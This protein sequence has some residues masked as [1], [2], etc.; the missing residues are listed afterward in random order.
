MKCTLCNGAT[1]PFCNTNNKHYFKCLVCDAVLLDSQ[2]FITAEAE[3]KRYQLH[4]NNIED[5][6]YQ[7][8]VKPITDAVL[9]TFNNTQSGLDFG[10]GTGPVITKILRKKTFEMTTYDPFF[11]NNLNALKQTY[12]FIVCCEVIEHFNNP[13]KEF[14]RLRQLLKPNGK[15]YCM[16]S[17]L[18]ETIN[19]KTWYYK[20]DATHVIFY[21]PKT[22]YYIAK[23]FGFNKVVVKGNLLVFG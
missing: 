1:T 16:T 10:S 14:M 19:F 23:T 15:M 9:N 12:D 3:K 13:Q 6:G 21:T 4:Q 18:N 5:I 17:V 20:N 22:A 11:D 7:Q 8:F 2:F